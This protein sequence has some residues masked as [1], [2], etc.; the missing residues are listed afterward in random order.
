MLTGLSPKNLTL[1]GRIGQE[2]R[3]NLRQVIPGTRDSGGQVKGGA[4]GRRPRADSSS[5]NGSSLPTWT[6][7]PT[8]S[9]S[10]GRC[11]ARRLR[12]QRGLPEPVTTKAP[13]HTVFCR[14]VD[15]AVHSFSFTEDTGSG[16]PIIMWSLKTEKPHPGTMH[17]TSRVRLSTPTPGHFLADFR[18][19]V[20]TAIS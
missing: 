1:E 6:V 17:G 7:G 12:G 10:E 4:D 2:P 19:P 15:P 18:K 3:G 5:G 14:H 8:A 13:R 9:I 16:L 20:R 11:T